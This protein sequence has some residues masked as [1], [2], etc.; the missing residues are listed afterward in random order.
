[1]NTRHTLIVLAALVTAGFGWQQHRTAT[2]IA[3][4]EQVARWYLEGTGQRNL[5]S[6][7]RAF[8][9]DHARLQFVRDGAYQNLPFRDW[10]A[11]IEASPD[12][13]P[14]DRE[15]IIASVDVAGDAAV[16]KILLIYPNGTRITDYLSLLKR[17][18]EWKIVNKIFTRE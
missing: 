14:A 9:H 8:D 15:E 4:V 6:L 12:N 2:D 13:G 17:E 11:R 10:L 5:E 18:G 16:A 3:E 1:M 7:R